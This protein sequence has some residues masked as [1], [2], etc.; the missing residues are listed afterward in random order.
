MTRNSRWKHVKAIVI[1][2]EY[3]ESNNNNTEVTYS[4][5]WAKFMRKLFIVSICLAFLGLNTV[6]IINGNKS[7][8]SFPSL[9]LT[10][11]GLMAFG[12]LWIAVVNCVTK[13]VIDQRFKEEF[14]I[15]LKTNGR[16]SQVRALTDILANIKI[17]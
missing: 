4:L 13:K 6:V 16:N 2:G 9:I 12:W 7:G 8:Y 5:C 3:K 11:N 10:L 14:E 1:K 15:E 17:E